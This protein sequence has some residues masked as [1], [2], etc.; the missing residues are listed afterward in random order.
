M[1]GEEDYLD[2]WVNGADWHIPKGDAID[3]K[4]NWTDDADLD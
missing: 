3:E 4:G 2:D 1:K